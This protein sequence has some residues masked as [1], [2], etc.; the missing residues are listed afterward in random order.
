MGIDLPQCVALSKGVAC[1]VC[2]CSMKDH[3]QG[4]LAWLTHVSIEFK[5]YTHVP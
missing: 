5:I 4:N 1:T 2:I 3:T